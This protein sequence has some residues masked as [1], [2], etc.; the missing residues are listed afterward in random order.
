M[1]K[2][3][4]SVRLKC[5]CGCSAV[6]VEKTEWDDGE[7]DYDI[8]IQD[9]RYDHNYTTFWGRLKT[10]TKILF[11]KPIYYSDVY[12]EKP[13]IYKKFVDDLGALCVETVE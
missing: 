3:E 8:S 13:E 4:A 11:G 7:I 5:S 12:I 10:A 1:D 6:V 9:S 2:K